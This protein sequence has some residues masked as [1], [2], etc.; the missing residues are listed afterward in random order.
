MGRRSGE[1]T[2]A[3]AIVAGLLAVL[4]LPT[5]GHAGEV[6]AA[7]VPV[8]AIDAIPAGCTLFD[9]YNLGGW[10]IER[11]WPEVAVSEDGRNDMYG[12]AVLRPQFDLMRGKVPAEATLDS[13][14][15]DC[16]LVQPD[17]ELTAELRTSPAWREA[18]TDPTGV[19]FL[20]V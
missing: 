20:R 9:D 17:R 6:D 18:V 12:T 1:L 4:A 14:G 10:V 13:M 11:R 16:V 15:V 8:H 7:A 3:L 5:L 2:T 19:L